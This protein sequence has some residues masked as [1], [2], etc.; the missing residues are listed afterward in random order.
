MT[1]EI[2]FES[3]KVGETL[4]PIEY[5]VSKK[6][7][8]GYCDNWKDFNPMYLE[9]SPFGDPPTAPGKGVALEMETIIT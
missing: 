2:P 7:V 1:K 4:G 3:I 8:Q 9:G 5:V 6:A